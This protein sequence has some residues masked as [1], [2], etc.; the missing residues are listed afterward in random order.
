[1]SR[2]LTCLVQGFEGDNLQQGDIARRWESAGRLLQA[3]EP[4]KRLKRA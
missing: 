4:R 1:M 3:C 2:G